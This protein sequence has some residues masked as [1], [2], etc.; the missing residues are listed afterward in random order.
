M[1]AIQ[2]PGDGRPFVLM[3]DHQPTGGYP[4]IACI[5]KADLPRMAQMTPGE[6]FTLHWI[7]PEQGLKRWVSMNE[8][9]NSLTALRGLLM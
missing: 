5:C 6:L 9:L 7:T 4:K 8:Q 1:G 2:V 3:A